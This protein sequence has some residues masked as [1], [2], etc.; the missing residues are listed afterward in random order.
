MGIFFVRGCFLII[1]KKVEIIFS[2]FS[3]Y[4]GPFIKCTPL[5]LFKSDSKAQEV[6]FIKEIYNITWLDDC[7]SIQKIH[8]GFEI[9]LYQVKETEGS[10][11]TKK[12]L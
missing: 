3:T 9:S 8:R 12:I 4:V 6:V 5:G 11:N 10:F 2:S 7:I 1:I